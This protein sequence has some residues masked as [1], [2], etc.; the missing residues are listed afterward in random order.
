MRAWLADLVVVVHFLYILFLI[1]G[2]LLSLRWPRLR[3]VHLV[4][5]GLAVVI[6]GFAFLCPITALEIWLRGGWA[7]R[8]GEPSFIARY[9]EP[10]V[11]P[12]LSQGTITALTFLLAA[13]TVLLYLWVARKGER[14]RAGA[15]QKGMTPE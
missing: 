7:E 10:V 5:I 14:V 15:G 6:Q 12:G 11:Y 13:V 1:L 3:K 9:I 8:G 2:P 4:A